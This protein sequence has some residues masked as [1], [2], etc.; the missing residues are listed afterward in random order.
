MIEPARVRQQLHGVHRVGTSGGYGVAYG[1]FLGGFRMDELVGGGPSEIA[2]V[3][4][5][6]VKDVH[7]EFR[8]HFAYEH[9]LLHEFFVKPVLQA[10]RVGVPVVVDP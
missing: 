2:V 8:T 5:Q 3:V 6:V 4:E 7:A 9:R 1:G 10:F